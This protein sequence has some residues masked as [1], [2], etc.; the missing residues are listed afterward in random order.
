M[1]ENKSKDSG[2]G[3]NGTHSNCGMRSGNEEEVLIL[4]V[5]TRR[6]MSEGGGSVNCRDEWKR[7]RGDRI[8]GGVVKGVNPD[9]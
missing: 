6:Q 5:A 9:R 1:N 2:E 7:N 3:R 8:S 4:V